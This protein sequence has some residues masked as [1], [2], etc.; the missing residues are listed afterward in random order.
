MESQNVIIK[1]MSH[2][3]EVCWINQEKKDYDLVKRSLILKREDI[4][5]AAERLER[6]APFI[7]ECFPETHKNH[8]LIESPLSAVSQTKSLLLQKGFQIPEGELYI[9]QDNCLDIAG[10]VKARGGVYEVLKWAEEIAEKEGILKKDSDYACLKN[11]RDIFGKYKIQVGSTGNLGLSIGIMSAAIGFEVIVHMSS[12]A[13][14]WKK[15]LL[16]SKGVKVIEYDSDYSV[17]V[18]EGRKAAAEDALCH[19]VDDE[20]SKELFLGYAVAAKRLKTQF[21]EQGIVIDRKHPLF[22]YL[23]C[24]VGGAPGGI[25]FGL[26][27]VFG[28][29]AHCFFVEPVECPCMILGLVSGKHEQICIKDIGLSGRTAADGLAVGRCSSLSADMMEYV[30]DGGITVADNILNEYMRI[31]EKAN[32]IFIEPSSCAAFAGYTGM[33][34]FKEA[35][36]YIE[37]NNLSNVMKNATHVLWATGGSL[38]PEH[39]REKYRNDEW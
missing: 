18:A 1:K 9:K 31:L 27:E 7:E 12:D 24:G 33:G 30:L 37:K 36:D 32:G 13:K 34:S 6:F 16:R 28:D 26:K 38:V 4:D 19:F 21:E 2:R 15:D 39:I 14:Q 11:Y 25:T 17:A 23:P 29:A 3:E 20:H 22:V 5:D 35:A 8:G 10:S